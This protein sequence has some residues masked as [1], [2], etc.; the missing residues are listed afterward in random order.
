MQQMQSVETR[1]NVFSKDPFQVSIRPTPVPGVSKSPLPKG[2]FLLRLRLWLLW[3]TTLV[4]ATQSLAQSSAQRSALDLLN[5]NRPVLDAHNCY[6]YE[7]KWKDRIERALSTGFPVAIEQDLAWANGRPVLSHTKETTGTEPTL[8]EHFFERVRGIVESALERNDR[9]RWPIITVHFDFKD[10]QPPLLEAVWKLLGEYEAW[11]TTAPKT[12]DPRKLS[13]FDPKPLL[14]LTEDNDDQEQVFFNALPVG[15]KLRLFGSAH[16]ARIEGQTRE[17][18]ERS[19]ATMSPDR[20]LVAPPTNYRRWWNNSWFVVEE[21]GQ[22]RGGPWNDTKRQRLEALVRHAH[23]LGYWIRFYTLDGFAPSED[24]GWGENYNF[25]S[26]DAVLL[27]WRAA[28]DAGVNLI[29]TDQ[30]EDLGKLMH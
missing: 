25:G 6:P 21:G 19:Q 2:G 13:D 10:N 9:A 12:A 20:L 26:R 18:R 3:T 1:S 23:K 24:R 27:R 11:I 16:T 7:G 5:G 30:F 8:R 4:L 22:R 17:E 15:A 29:A 14:V 28:I